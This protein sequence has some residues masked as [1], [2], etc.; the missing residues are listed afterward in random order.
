MQRDTW[1]MLR[2]IPYGETRSYGWV[3]KEIGRPG[4]ARPVGTING[5]NPIPLWLPC[6]RVI[7]SDGSLTGY[8]GGLE[9]K[10]QILEVEG[11]IPKALV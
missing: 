10:R 5:A 4:M 7:G 6:H 1:L 2:K 3:A 9:M 11:A 8:G